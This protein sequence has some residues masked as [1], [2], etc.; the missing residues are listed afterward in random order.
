MSTIKSSAENLTL[1]ADGSGNDV[2]IQSNG[3]TKA[4]VTAE[5][6]VG[7]GITPDAW[8]TSLQAIQIGDYGSINEDT[9]SKTFDI[10][11]NSYQSAS[12]DLH[13]NTDEA[14]MFRQGGGKFHFYQAVSA[15]ADAAASWTEPLRIDTTGDI[16]VKTGDIV[17]GT[18]GKGIV[19]GATTN[20]DANTLDDYEEGSWTIA[21][22]G[23]TSG[24]GNLT[25]GYYTKI[26][27]MVHCT[28]TISN[29]TFP[30]FAGNLNLSLPF[31]GASG[32]SNRQENS[33]DVYFYP[34][35][36][37]TSGSTFTGLSFHINGD[38]STTGYFQIKRVATDRQS[39]LN[40][41][42]GSISGASGM[43]CRFS[44]TYTAT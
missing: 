40:S 27:R 35:S 23:S 24:S 42:Q 44:V 10:R 16:Q 15:S 30:T 43:Y 29:T 2:L 37:W 17:F 9:G 18:A 28:F 14:T 13:T 33:G 11:C 20:V 6:N 25:T 32:M 19:L 34:L 26:G 12:A 1:N 36:K 38:N 41:N 4:I 31:T 3:S 7:I 21:L 39:Q 22:T 8:S 5:G